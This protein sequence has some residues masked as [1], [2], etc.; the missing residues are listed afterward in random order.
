MAYPLLDTTSDE[1]T[2]IPTS[3]TMVNTIINGSLCERNSIPARITSR[4]SLSGCLSFP[5]SLTSFRNIASYSN[6]RKRTSNP[7]NLVNVP[8]TTSNLEIHRDNCAV[9]SFFVTNACHIA[10]KVDEL[11]AVVA[12]NNPS[13]ILVTDPGYRLIFRILLLT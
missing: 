6:I 11:S 8:V 5:R 2:N 4:Y 12:I 3:F 7:C 10:N 9:P 1:Y 13:V